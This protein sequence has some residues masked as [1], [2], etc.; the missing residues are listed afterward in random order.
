MYDKCT[1]IRP[2]HVPQHTVRIQNP[3]GY[4]W[5]STVKGPAHDSRSCIVT[6]NVKDYTC[7]GMH[8]L[9]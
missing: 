3:Q 9:P 2:P 8:L 6:E 7:N 1:G 5:A 4:N